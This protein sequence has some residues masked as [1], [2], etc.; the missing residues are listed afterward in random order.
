MRVFFS[1]NHNAKYRKTKATLIY[2]WHSYLK[3]ALVENWKFFSRNSPPNPKSGVVS[4]NLHPQIQWYSKISVHWSMNFPPTQNVLFSIFRTAFRTFPVTVNLSLGSRYT[5][6]T[7]SPRVKERY[8]IAK[9]QTIHDVC[10]DRTRQNERGS[11]NIVKLEK[12]FC[13]KSNYWSMC[14]MAWQ[15]IIISYCLETEAGENLIQQLISWT[16]YSPN[17]A[18]FVMSLP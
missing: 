1:I 14:A 3:T 18:Y 13:S 9:A 7:T 15:S 6:K 11:Q 4:L 8:L 10:F 5:N 12:Y 17:L 2:F 16:E